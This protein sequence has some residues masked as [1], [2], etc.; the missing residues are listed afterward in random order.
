LGQHEGFLL[1]RN[2][3]HFA[4]GSFIHP[5]F[6]AAGVADMAILVGEAGLGWAK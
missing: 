2:Q 6:D 1:C 5:P 4:Q 3:G